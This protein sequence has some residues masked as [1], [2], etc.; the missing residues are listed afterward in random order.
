MGHSLTKAEQGMLDSVRG[1][2]T[3]AITSPEQIDILIQ[4]MLKASELTYNAVMGAVK[5]DRAL[6]KAI[7]KR[8]G[9]LAET[10]VEGNNA[11]VQTLLDTYKANCDA[12]RSF[13]TDPSSSDMSIDECFAQ[14]RYYA[15]KMYEIQQDVRTANQE[16]ANR[17]ADTNEIVL[18][19]SK[20]N[21]DVLIGISLGVGSATILY[22][23]IKIVKELTKK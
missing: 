20:K 6:C 13:M 8:M 14:L 5:E 16:I 21:R 11:S 17:S 15:D 4:G 10:L 7:S 3:N 23:C 1:T 22:G 12:I 9:D 19:R 18:D 2:G